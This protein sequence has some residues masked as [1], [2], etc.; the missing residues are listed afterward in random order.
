MEHLTFPIG[1]ADSLASDQCAP[2]P[3]RPLSSVW[4]LSIRMQAT[5]WY[6]SCACD[7]KFFVLS[8]FEPQGLVMSATCVPWYVLCAN[9]DL[10]KHHDHVFSHFYPLNQ[11]LGHASTGSGGGGGGQ[12]GCSSGG[13]MVGSD[14]LN[15]P[16]IDNSSH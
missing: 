7:D 2:R 14:R 5:E 3:L 10:S 9:M 11:K 16:A 4:Q 12:L 8:C 6:V 15:V 1:R 13:S